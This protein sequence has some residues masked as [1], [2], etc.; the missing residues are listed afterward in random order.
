MIEKKKTYSGSSYAHIYPVHLSSKVNKK[1]LFAL[2]KIGFNEKEAE[3]ALAVSNNF[4]WDIFIGQLLF[5]QN[6]FDVSV[7]VRFLY[8]CAQHRWNIEHDKEYAE[9]FDVPTLKGSF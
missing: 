4:N 1:K 8:E 5:V 6:F 7:A 3:E 9:K 2:T